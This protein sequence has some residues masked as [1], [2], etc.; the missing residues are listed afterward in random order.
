MIEID[1]DDAVDRLRCMAKEIVLV[2]SMNE[3][4]NDSQFKDKALLINL[5]PL[6]MAIGLLGYGKAKR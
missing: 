6:V 2:G 3:T 4:L 5:I 1:I